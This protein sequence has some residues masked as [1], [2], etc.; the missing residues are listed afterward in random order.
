MTPSKRDLHDRL[1]DLEDENTTEIP[2][3]WKDEIPPELWNSFEEAFMYS[4][5]QYHF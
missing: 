3:G 4:L 2:E 1:N 5:R